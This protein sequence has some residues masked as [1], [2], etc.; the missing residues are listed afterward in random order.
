MPGGQENIHQIL[1]KAICNDLDHILVKDYHK[2]ISYNQEKQVKDD[3]LGH[4][5]D[6]QDYHQMLATF[7]L[8]LL[9]LGAQDLF[10]EFLKTLNQHYHIPEQV[11]ATCIFEIIL[12][13]FNSQGFAGFQ[14]YKGSNKKEQINQDKYQ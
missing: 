14:G 12:Q 10:D 2:V 13:G 5:K 11:I 3:E 9:R 4:Y 8:N 7:A 6:I 1:R